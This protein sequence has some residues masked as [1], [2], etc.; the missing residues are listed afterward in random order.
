M[1]VPLPNCF[2]IWAKATCRALAFSLLTGVGALT[3]VTGASMKNLLEYQQVKLG[4]RPMHLLVLMT[5]WML[6][7]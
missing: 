6:E 7:Q 2:S 3:G 5:G 4:L 1:M